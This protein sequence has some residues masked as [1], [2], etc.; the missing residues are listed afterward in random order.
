M[1]QPLLSEMANAL[2]RTAAGARRIQ[3]RA[4][5]IAW[6]RTSVEAVHNA[7]QR[8]SNLK[9]G[10]LSYGDAFGGGWLKS[11]WSATGK[12]ASA[13]SPDVAPRP[14]GLRRRPIA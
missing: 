11:T 14:Q 7:E 12:P 13:E 3:T 4:Q 1:T 10:V 6:S 8:P 2:E 9:T 5:A